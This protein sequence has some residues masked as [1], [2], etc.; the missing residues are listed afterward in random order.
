MMSETRMNPAA[1]RPAG[2]T[3]EWP[4]NYLPLRCTWSMVGRTLIDAANGGQALCPPV[5]F[6]SSG[7]YR[8][9]DEWERVAPLIVSAINNHDPL[10]EALANLIEA[11]EREDHRDMPATWRHALDDARAALASAKRGTP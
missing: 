2:H 6:G 5:S 3:P 7:W 4:V 8:F 1:P 10:M 9:K 11:A